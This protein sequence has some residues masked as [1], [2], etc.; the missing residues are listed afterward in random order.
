M[1]IQTY[2]PVRAEIFGKKPTMTQRLIMLRS[3]KTHTEAQFSDL[4]DNISCSATRMDGSNCVRFKDIK[5]SHLA[6]RWDTVDVPMSP[7]GENRSYSMARKLLGMPYDLFGQLC[8]LT[9]LKIIRPSEK[10]IWCTKTVAKIIY[11]GR[12][13]FE[14]FMVKYGLY[15]ELRPDQ[16][17]TMA[18]YYFRK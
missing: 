10:R 1:K 16:F 11:A 9:P 4:F 15:E 8:H 7:E 17:Y 6:Q 14:K 12:T 18:R 5:Y 2:N 13:D 3:G